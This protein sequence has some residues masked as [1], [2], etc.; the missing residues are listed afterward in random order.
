MPLEKVA[1]LLHFP[2]PPMPDALT[3]TKGDG[4]IEFLINAE[5]SDA[6]LLDEVG[7]YG[8]A[9]LYSPQFPRMIAKIGHAYAFAEMD[10]KLLDTFEK[11]LPDIILSAPGEDV[12][13]YIGSAGRRRPPPSSNMHELALCSIVQNGAEYLVAKIRLFAHLDGVV[14]FALVGS[15][16][17][18]GAPAVADC[19]HL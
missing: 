2:A 13:R 5:L 6:A 18:N 14:Y 3:G 1:K 19:T 12:W 9:I 15:R 11:F 17:F 16:F 10:A 4:S 8:L 7:A